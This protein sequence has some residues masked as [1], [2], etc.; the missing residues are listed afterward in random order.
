MTE[1]YGIT[2]KQLARYAAAEK[3]L[4]EARRDAEA[5]ALATLS[6]K[7]GDIVS[8]R[9]NALSYKIDSMSLSIWRGEPKLRVVAHR[10]YRSGR[11]AGKLAYTPSYFDIEDVVKAEQA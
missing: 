5:T 9:Y 1:L 7:S 10:Y 4:A 2:N 6:Y 3:E 8:S 11:R